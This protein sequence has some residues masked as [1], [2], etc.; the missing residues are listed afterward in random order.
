[1]PASSKGS[2]G[3]L[4]AVAA[5]FGHLSVGFKLSL[6]FG[7]VLLLT[8]IMVVAALHAIKVLQAASD[9]QRLLDGLQLTLAETRQ[10][11]KDFGLTLATA[12][13]QQVRARLDGLQGELQDGAVVPA[14][15]DALQGY[16][17]AFDGYVSALQAA[18]QARLRMQSLAKAAGQRFAGLFI[19]Q[20]DSIN[21]SLE[22]SAAPTEEQMQQLEDAVSLRERLA[23]L[24]DSELAFSLD[25]Q[26]QSRDD[27]E[28][29]MSELA[30]ALT[31]LTTRVD[32]EQRQGLE[33]ARQALADY[34]QAFLDYVAGNQVAARAETQMT[35]VAQQVASL[36]EHERA[37]RA[38]AHA[39]SQ[40]TLRI[41][42]LVLGLLA[43][44]LGI[45][46]A[47]LIRRAIIVPLR[48]M[49]GLAQ[50]VAAGALRE[51]PATSLRRDELGQ[52]LEAVRHM[53][54]ALR[55]L[56]GRIDTDVGQLERVAGSL[57]NSAQRTGDGVSAQRELTDWVAGA[58]QRMTDSC[59]TISE[60]I[61]ASCEAL[62]DAGGLAREG[63]GLVSRASER[64]QNVAREMA[65]SGASML[66]LQEQSASITRVLE[67]INALAE[68]TNLL[69][70]NAAIE[71]ARAGEHGR[72]FAVVA[73]EVRALASRTSES[74]GEIEVMIRRLGE[75]TRATADSL[76]GS[77]AFT[78]QGVELTGQASAVLTSITRT[79]VGVETSARAI[80]A[81]AAAQ[82]DMARQVDDAV[83]RVARVVEQ[84][85]EDCHLL[86][87]ASGSLQQVEVSLKMAVGAFSGT[88]S[89]SAEPIRL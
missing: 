37:A 71:A 51:M 33:E 61:A 35:S 49:L 74:T 21:L 16:A 13:A 78:A 10:V 87:T 82:Y 48:Q 38:D 58:M 6:G 59:A 75:L 24:R 77:Q 66:S 36:L 2:A 70:L 69:A 62:G 4:R 73:D 31:N 47:L 76:Q 50:R 27:W 30:T 89:E 15:G 68:Q 44:V 43:L 17:S 81:A 65:T 88:R 86:Q 84:N 23:N 26:R 39:S 67:V 20:F 72:G 28:N 56:V 54:D 55:G 34:R 52:L 32:D 85:A 14:L 22:Q 19:D 5:W 18:R 1:M 7:L 41:Q 60:Q 64:L 45:G 12:T 3:A 46:A 53:L 80:D 40:H 42:L 25:P 57:I 8:L 83:A 79:M 29:R 63:D 11:E 9:E